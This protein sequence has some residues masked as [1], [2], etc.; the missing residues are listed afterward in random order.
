MIFPYINIFQV[1][2]DDLEFKFSLPVHG[3]PFS[4]GCDHDMNLA[5]ATMRKEIF[6]FNVYDRHLIT[7]FS[8]GLKSRSKSVPIQISMSNESEVNSL[9]Y[10]SMF[11]DLQ[12]L[13]KKSFLKVLPKFGRMYVCVCPFD[14]SH[15]VQPRVLKFWHNIPHVTI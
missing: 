11:F 3:E 10:T 5:V 1:F 12:L 14:C 4:L 13:R 15:T 9:F 8:V 2:T 6:V 7:K